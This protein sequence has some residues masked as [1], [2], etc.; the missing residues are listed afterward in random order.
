MPSDKKIMGAIE[1]KGAEVILLLPNLRKRDQK[2][3]EEF[4]TFLDLFFLSLAPGETELW[5][6]AEVG[7]PAN[8][9]QCGRLRGEKVGEV[10]PFPWPLP[11][12]VEPRLMP[13]RPG[14]LSARPALLEV[15]AGEKQRSS[16]GEADL[17][18]YT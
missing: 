8:N 2:Q 15:T 10:I 7:L 17:D 18:N 11:C 3:F 5:L 1:V 9:R 4:F 12:T 16:V 13:G 6:G 14:Q